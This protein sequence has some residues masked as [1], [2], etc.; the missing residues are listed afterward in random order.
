M[1]I[2]QAFE[3]LLKEINLENTTWHP[4]KS[5]IKLNKI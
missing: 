3:N 5:F 4:V 1:I 2:H